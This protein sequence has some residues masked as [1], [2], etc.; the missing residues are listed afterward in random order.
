MKEQAMPVTILPDVIHH[1][2]RKITRPR[3]TSAVQPEFNYDLSD[4]RCRIVDLPL[5][6][7]TPEEE[8]WREK[9]KSK[10]NL[11]TDFSGFPRSPATCDE[12]TNESSCK[13]IGQCLRFKCAFGSVNKP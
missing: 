13:R 1:P 8:D 12:C 9:C 6:R 10:F 2:D 5:L 7:D 4:P 3:L 11:L